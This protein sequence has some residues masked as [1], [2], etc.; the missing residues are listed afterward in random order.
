M[1]RCESGDMGGKHGRLD[2]SPDGASRPTYTYVDSNLQLT[3]SSS[4]EP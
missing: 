1:H 3:G 4:S 2:L